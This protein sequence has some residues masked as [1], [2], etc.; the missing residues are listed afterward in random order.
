[1]P[2]NCPAA[3]PDAVAAVRR[4]SRF[5]TRQLGLL[6]AGLLDSAF[7]LTEARVLYELAN[8]P[9]PTAAELGRDLGIDAGYLSRILKGFETRGLLT[10]SASPSDAREARLHLTEPGAP[11]SR[12]WTWR[13]ARRSAA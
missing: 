2:D 8:R 11:P 13:P 6:D 3:A 9:A 7:S 5:Y 10:R 1:M 4:F 12:R